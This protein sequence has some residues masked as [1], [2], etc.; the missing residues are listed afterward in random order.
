MLTSQELAPRRSTELGATASAARG[1]TTPDSPRPMVVALDSNCF[2]DAT[3]PD[4]PSFGPMRCI[5][6]S[7][8]QGR[9]ALTV[10]RH[11]LAELDARLDEARALSRLLPILPHWPIGTWGEQVCTWEQAEGTWGDAS[12]NDDIQC[13]LAVLAKSGND[14]RDRGAFLDA[15]KAGVDLFVTSDKQLVGS[16]PAKRI[17]DRFGL[18]VVTPQWLAEAL[19]EA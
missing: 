11:T 19:G 15:L 7:R 6:R 16:G 2:I 5:L 4:S 18:R 10:S 14:L 9:V 17:G 13:E 3:N 12:Q 8:D 1:Q